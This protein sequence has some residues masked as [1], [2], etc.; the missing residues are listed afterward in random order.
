[1]K[2]QISA[3]LNSRSGESIAEV[4]VALLISA[5][6]L[7]MLA[8]MITSSVDLVTKSRQT[9]DAYYRKNAV[10]AEQKIGVQVLDDLNKAKSIQI[11]LDGKS[12]SYGL[13]KADEEI[14]L[15]YFINDKNARYPV[16]S[17]K[18]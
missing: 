3:K 11:S 7:V 6:A 1:M 13:V 16:V 5:L 4:L 10:V 15:S 12:G 2:K 17:Y 9:M 18:K 8:S 14:S